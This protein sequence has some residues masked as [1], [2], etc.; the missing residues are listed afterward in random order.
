MNNIIEQYKTIKAKYPDAILFFRIG[1]FYELFNGDAETASK[2]LGLEL[3]TSE[4]DENIIRQ[5]S[6]P[7]YSLDNYLQ[8]FV[9]AGYRIAVCDQLENQKT[10]KNV[11]RGVTDVK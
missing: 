10:N 7:Y 8:K 3:K 9:R 6:F 1:D 4:A 2:I 11:K 5:V